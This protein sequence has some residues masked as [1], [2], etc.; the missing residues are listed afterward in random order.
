MRQ[1]HSR[2]LREL[3][4]TYLGDTAFNEAAGHA[5]VFVEHRLHPEKRRH[6]NG[7]KRIRVHLGGL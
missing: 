6:H 1:L 7:G 3:I 2:K 5:R 4:A